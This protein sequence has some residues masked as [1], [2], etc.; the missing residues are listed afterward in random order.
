[1]GEPRKTAKQNTKRGLLPLRSEL[2]LPQRVFPWEL[3]LPSGLL[4]GRSEAEE[5]HRDA[6]T[7]RDESTSN[8]QERITASA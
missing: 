3:E 7:N 6:G 4:E 5:E 2:T 1:M 8:H